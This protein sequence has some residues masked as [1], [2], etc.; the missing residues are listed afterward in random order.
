VPEELAESIGWLAPDLEPICDLVLGIRSSR[1]HRDPS[2]LG[3]TRQRVP[4]VMEAV[5]AERRGGQ[6]DRTSSC[7]AAALTHLRQERQQLTPLS[8]RIVDALSPGDDRE[9]R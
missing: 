3:L 5:V 6:E 9:L 1:G 2:L 7:L 8:H 4:R